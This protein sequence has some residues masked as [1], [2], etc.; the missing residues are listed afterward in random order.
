[1]IDL[2]PSSMYTGRISMQLRNYVPN[3]V[4]QLGS[5]IALHR[6]GEKKC[7]IVQYVHLRGLQL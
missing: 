3:H 6:L 1:M 4:P 2:A 7:I 5:S